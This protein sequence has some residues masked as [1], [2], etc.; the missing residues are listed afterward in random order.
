M[1]NHLT[2]EERDYIAQ[3]KHQGADQKEIAKALNRSPATISR[4]LRRNRAGDDYFPA[5]AQRQAELRRRERPITRKLDDPELNDTVR[6]GLVQYWSP[7]QVAGRLQQHD[8]D[9]KCQVSARTIYHWIQHDKHR[10][11]WQSFL[12]RRGK[13]PSSRKKPAGIGAPIDQRP[14]VIEQR[15]RLG[16]FEGDTVLGPPGTGG[17]ATLVDR[18]SRYTIIVKINSKNADHV[19][20]KIRDRLK[21]LDEERRRSVTFDNGSEFARCHRLEKHLGIDLYFADPGCPHQRGTNENT[22]GLIRQFFPKGIEFRDITHHQVREVQTLLNNRPRACLGYRTPEEV[23]FD[24]Y[25]S[26]NCI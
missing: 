10:E 1:A 26:K 3:L 8:P 7:E 6:K 18:K 2:M 14:E 11:H 16:D 12:R 24:D 15:L 13:R 17:L 9:G 5:Q 4:E 25:A 22:N 21:Q 20:Q 23:F 19:Q